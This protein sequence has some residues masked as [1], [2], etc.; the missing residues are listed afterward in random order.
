MSAKSVGHRRS[1]ELCGRKLKKNGTNSAGRTRWRCPTCGTSTVRRRV[2][3]T[4][5]ADFERFLAWLLGPL[6]QG[7]VSDASARTFRRDTT[8]CWNV[9]PVIPVTGEIYDEVQV[10]G[11]YLSR[12]WC[13]LI[14]SVRGKPIGWQ[15]CDQEKSV[16]WVALLVQF[17]A[18]RVVVADGGTGLGA[19]LAQQWAGTDIQRCL[20]HVQRN[21]RTYL[22]SNPRTDAGKA[23]LGL[24]KTLTGIT[25]QQRAVQWLQTLNDW[26]ELYAHLTTERTYLK[27]VQERSLIPGWVR[28]G[29]T[30]WYTHAN[31]RKAYRLLAKL[32]QAGHLF[33]YLQPEHAGRGISST[34][35]RAEGAIN[36]GIR[37]LLRRHRGMPITH[38][39]RAVEWFLYAHSFEPEPANTLITPQHYRVKKDKKPVTEEQ[40]GPVEFDTG[41]SSE[42]GLWTRKGW[43]GRS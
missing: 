19:A 34:T 23:L 15:W 36:A 11:I 8:W 38:Q 33:T 13:H 6:G 31:L 5:K 28:P 9:E 21:V 22:T 20:V 32:T 18:P 35:N 39:R 29:Q 3:V 1:C 30:W 43:A 14:A 27:T 42:E 24:G 26:Y 7:V 12:N 41:L 37:E 17:P 40:I 2:D 10:D 25:S 16:A 4:R